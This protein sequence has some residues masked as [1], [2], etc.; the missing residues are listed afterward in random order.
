MRLNKTKY[1]IEDSVKDCIDGIIKLDELKSKLED[2]KSDL[3][4]ISEI[5]TTHAKTGELFKLP[6]ISTAEKDPKVVKDLTKSELIKIYSQ[7]FVPEGKPARKI[8]DAILN[9]SKEECPFCGGIGVPKNLDHFL[10]KS[11][12]P[13]FSILPY[14]LI[15][16]CLDCN[17]TEKKENFSSTP[18]A[19]IIHPYLDKDIFFTNQWI[20]AEYDELTKVFTFFTSIPLTWCEYDKKKALAHFKDFNIAKRYAKKASQAVS[21]PL[22]QISMMRSFKCSNDNINQ[23]IIK[24]GIDASPFPNHWSSIMF[25]ALGRKLEEI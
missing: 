21:V 20:D 24:P 3:V 23:C 9:S 17:L 8:Y 15:P 16:S 2:A 6:Q 13:Q 19:Q 18:E 12:F 14:N 7:F 25:K 10:P 1:G 4:N 11:Q 5:Y 22:G